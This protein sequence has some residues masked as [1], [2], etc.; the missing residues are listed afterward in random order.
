MENPIILGNGRSA[1]ATPVH[2][3]PTR[4]EAGPGKRSQWW[5]WLHDMAMFTHH[6][7]NSVGWIL[8]C[9]TISSH[10]TWRRKLVLQW[11]SWQN[12]AKPT[13]QAQE[14]RHSKSF[15]CDLVNF[16]HAAHGQNVSKPSNT[17]RL[18]SIPLI[19]KDPL[20]CLTFVRW[21]WWLQSCWL[22]IMVT[23]MVNSLKVKCPNT[24][25]YHEVPSCTIKY[26]KNPHFSTVVHPALHRQG[27]GAPVIHRGI[28]AAVRSQ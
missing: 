14:W 16:C 12:N 17:W 10:Q 8:D 11:N 5:Q 19:P 28:V 15:M 25:K 18:I 6:H 22:D 4:E 13:P 24:I 27:Q 1:R 2:A 7:T 21:F 3:V 23:Q 20:P 9:S 26:P